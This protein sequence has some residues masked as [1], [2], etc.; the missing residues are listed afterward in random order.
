MASNVIIFNRIR[1]IWPKGY[2][3]KS[4]G[5]SHQNSNYLKQAMLQ[6]C[7]PTGIKPAAFEFSC[8]TTLSHSLFLILILFENEIILKQKIIKNIFC[9]FFVGVYYFK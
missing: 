7:P 1:A 3:H 4:L 5:K 8:K 6:S 9:T 2:W